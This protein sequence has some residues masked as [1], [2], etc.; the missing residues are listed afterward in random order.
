MAKATDPRLWIRLTL[1][2]ADHPKIVRLSDRAFRT[3]V[4]MLLWSKRG[5]TDGVLPR[6]Y[7][8]RR[9]G[10]PKTQS[11]TDSVTQSVSDPVSELLSNDPE[12]PSLEVLPNG[13]Y[14]IHDYCDHQETRADVESR[15]RRNQANGKRGGRPPKTQSV[16]ESV[17]QSLTQSGGPLAKQTLDV[18]RTDTSPNGEVINSDAPATFREFWSA[19]PKRADDSE[20]SAARAWTEATKHATPRQILDGA[21]RYAADPNLPPVEWRVGAKRWLEEQRWDSGPLP[22]RRDGPDM[23]RSNT[24]GWMDLA[25]EMAMQEHAQ[26]GGPL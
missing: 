10:T 25:H 2:M 9:W 16:T 19:W 1:D 17:T 3:L 14:M 22:P 23:G 4:E 6:E 24:Q 13:D 7:V 12:S 5:L 11:L 21:K 18:R 20:M 15:K 26:I 8:H